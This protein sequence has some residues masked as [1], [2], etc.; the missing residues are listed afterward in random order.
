MRNLRTIILAIAAILISSCK[1]ADNE[2][3]RAKYIFL[4]IGD[5]MGMSHVAVTESYLSY[6]ADTLAGVQVSFTQMP[7]LG[8]CTTHSAN[9]MITCSAA[10]AT[11]IAC[12]EKT[13][14]ER[15]GIGPD[16]EEL[17]S[18][19]YEL[20]DAGYKIG[21]MT[22]NPVN[23]ATPAG[24]YAHNI[25]RYGYYD[26]SKEIVESGFEFFGGSGFYNLRGAEGNLPSIDT[27]ISE[28]GYEVCYGREEFISK[29]DSTDNI[30]F[31]QESGKGQDPEY[32]VSDGAE[33]TDLRIAEILE[34]AIDYLGDEDPFFIMCEGGNID[35]AAHANKTMAMIMEVIDFDNAVKKAL[36]FYN[37]HPDETLIIVTA[38]HETGGVTLGQG[39][40]W[41]PEIIGWELLEKNWIESGE[42]NVLEFEANKALNDSALI[43]W[44][45]CHHTG[46]PVPVYAI[47]KGAE[48][49]AGRLDNIDIKGKILCE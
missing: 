47:G 2:P 14:N 36:D 22:N 28:N 3:E 8:L 38:D 13:N 49:F 44:T 19:A 16:G 27:Y 41:R 33:E 15:I 18:V 24:F 32:Y 5:G 17:T 46:S 23:H 20:H 10:S 26:I 25:S 21:I 7:Y 31:I 34:L 39:I 12:G 4:F 11:A 40:D 43:G 48:K 6:K 35:W 30:I 29:A 42:K 37:E 45:S 1:A 9:R